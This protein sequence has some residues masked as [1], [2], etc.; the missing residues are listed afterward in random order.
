MDVI[1]FPKNLQTT[2]GISILLRGAISLPA[3]TSCDKNRLNNLTP[4]FYKRPTLSTSPTL[5]G[6][7]ACEHGIRSSSLGSYSNKART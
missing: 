4:Q 7:P 3:V 5:K 1:T 6:T 2:S